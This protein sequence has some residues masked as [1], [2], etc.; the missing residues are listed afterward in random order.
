MV[1]KTGDT[2]GNGAVSKGVVILSAQGHF[3]TS[4]SRPL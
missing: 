2:H 3:F 4:N 1:V